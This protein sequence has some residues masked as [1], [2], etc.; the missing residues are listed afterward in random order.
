[1]S[2]EKFEHEGVRYSIF[3]SNHITSSY[4]LIKNA[5]G[6]K[7]LDALV[8]E[9]W[10][11][12]MDKESLPIYQNYWQYSEIFKNIPKENPDLKI[13]DIDF[14]NS[15][16]GI[17]SSIFVEGVLPLAAVGFGAT[18]F[19]GKMTRRS[20]F[21]RAAALG[22]GI[23]GATF[24][25]SFL[26]AFTTKK[27]IEPVS[28]LNNLR[29]CAL[30]SPLVGFRNAAAA[31]IIEEHIAGK[32]AKSIGIL[33]GSLHSGIEEYVKHPGIRDKTI[34]AYRRLGYPGVK[35][36]Q[37]DTIGKITYSRGEFKVEEIKLNLF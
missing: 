26:N 28:E 36:D 9:T 32:K 25:L 10:L 7:D 17:A 16:L 4:E 29:T 31:K 11:E 12:P 5:G 27:D 37:L 13:Y 33:Y 30:P 34:E 8:V 35:K 24:P 22:V 19:V 3:L 23:W 21:R 14:P 2:Y 20:L 6:L 1:M 15:I 18:A